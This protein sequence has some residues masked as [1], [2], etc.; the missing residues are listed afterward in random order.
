MGV[1]QYFILVGGDDAVIYHYKCDYDRVK[2][3]FNQVK[4]YGLEPETVFRK[5]Y[6]SA[7]FYSGFFLPCLYKKQE[8]WIHTLSVGKAF[9]KAFNYRVKPDLHPETWLKETAKQREV[10]WNHCP[11]L[12][13]V[14]EF[15]GTQLKDTVVKKQQ[16]NMDLGGFMYDDRMKYSVEESKETKHVLASIYDMDVTEIDSLE[17]DLRHQF[18]GD[19][20]GRKISSIGLTRMLDLDL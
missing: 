15:V 9:V 19:W 5:N 4:R 20:Y 11:I 14:P 6:L 1:N 10:M 2:E 12:N 3:V 18:S 16:V 7:R 13:L 17:K 8:H